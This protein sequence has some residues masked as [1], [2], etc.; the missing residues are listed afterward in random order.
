MDDNIL[1]NKSTNQIPEH[2]CLQFGLLHDLDRK[3][4][5]QL[6]EWINETQTNFMRCFRKDYPSLS[7]G[8]Y[9]I[10]MLI[11]IRLSHEEIAQIG[12]VTLKSFRMRRF[13]IKQ[14]MQVGCSHLTCFLLN[15]YQT[16]FHQNVIK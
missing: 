10:V 2:V 11:R 8:D 3:G 14:K 7:E 13:R 5:L 6:E 15:L 4:W 16:S 12:N 9:Q 1:K